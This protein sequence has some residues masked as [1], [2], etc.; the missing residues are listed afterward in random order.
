MS[1]IMQTIGIIVIGVCFFAG[2]ISGAS[3]VLWFLSDE[4]KALKSE[5]YDNDVSL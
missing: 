5:D 4:Y 1:S 2:L 3:T